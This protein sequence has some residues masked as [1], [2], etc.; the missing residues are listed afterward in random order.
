ML[1]NF[2]SRS[3]IF[4]KA[5][6]NDHYKGKDFFSARFSGWLCIDNYEDKARKIKID[7]KETKPEVPKIMTSDTKSIEEIKVA[8]YFPKLNLNE[9]QKIITG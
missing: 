1:F 7:L 3:R 5:L 8:F 9:K 2:Q 6:V 4:T